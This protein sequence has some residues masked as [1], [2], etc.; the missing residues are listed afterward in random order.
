VLPEALAGNAAVTELNQKFPNVIVEASLALG[1]VTLI[2]DPSALVPFCL[3]LR[4]AQSFDRL[5][6]VTAIDWWPAQLRFEVVYHLYSTKN[7]KRLRLK[8]RASEGDEIDSVTHVWPAANWYERE[9]FDLFGISFRNHPNLERI[10]MPADWQ[11]Y[12][13]R[14]DYPIDGYKYSY[15]HEE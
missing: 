11:G 4:D 12:P 15:A 1:E 7:N 2:L 6:S 9:V 10:M 14:K 13:L 3:A 5:S 8:V